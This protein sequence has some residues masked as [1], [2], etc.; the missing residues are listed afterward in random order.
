MH[1]KVRSCRL[2]PPVPLCPVSLGPAMRCAVAAC[3]L[4]S[5]QQFGG[6]FSIRAG[7]SSEQV[8]QSSVLLGAPNQSSAAQRS[9]DKSIEWGHFFII[10]FVFFLGTGPGFLSCGRIKYSR[11][12]G[13]RGPKGPEAE[14][15]PGLVGEEANGGGASTRPP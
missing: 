9:Q 6:Y 15:W 14:P 5:P 13:P 12:T 3:L 8:V 10:I 11:S 2:S 7:A 1:A 4:P